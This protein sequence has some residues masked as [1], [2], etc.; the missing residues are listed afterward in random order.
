MLKINLPLFICCAV[1][2]APLQAQI[3]SDNI[4][5]ERLD[6]RFDLHSD[7]TIKPLQTQVV[8]D[9]IP[10]DMPDDRYVLHSDG[11]ATDLHTGLLWQRCSIGQI[12]DGGTCA[13]YAHTYTWQE[14]L[15]Q[16]KDNELGGYG[17]WRLPNREEL[18]SIVAYDRYNPATNSRIFPEI[19]TS[20]SRQY[21]Y[22]SSS[23]TAYLSSLPSLS[24]NITVNYEHYS[25]FSSWVIDFKDGY[26]YYTIRSF[27]RAVRLVR[28]GQ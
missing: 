21:T 16:G 24:T 6:E 19:S 23:P 27:K 18:R 25:P 26:D 11:T 1:L 5:N 12:W 2:M 3:N 14:A 7:G 17:D 8:N 13:H 9:Y 4:P 10:N 20:S 22:W 15:R 28:G